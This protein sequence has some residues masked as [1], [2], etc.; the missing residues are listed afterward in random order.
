[1]LKYLVHSHIYLKILWK[2]TFFCLVAQSLS[3]EDGQRDE[4]LDFVMFG[5][6]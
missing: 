4:F 6:T 2:N 5:V 1:M 3:Y